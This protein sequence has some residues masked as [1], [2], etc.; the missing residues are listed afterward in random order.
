MHPSGEEIVRLLS[1][2]FQGIYD[3][4]LPAKP[5]EGRP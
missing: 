3:F 5:G 4:T 2:E 1:I